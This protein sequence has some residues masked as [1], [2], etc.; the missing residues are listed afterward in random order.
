MC[1]I[2][3]KRPEVAAPSDETLKIMFE[4]NPDGGGVA[5]SYKG[6]LHI[7]KGL[8]TFDEFLDAAHK[9]PQDAP[10]IYHT[11]IQTSGG[12][13]K[14][15]THPF[16]ID[17]DIKKQRQTKT[18]TTN[19]SA[20]AHNGIF[21]QYK[22]KDLNND[23][24]QF[25]TNNIAPLKALKDK[26]GGK[27]TDADIKNIIDELTGSSRVAILT[28]DGTLETYG[29]GWTTDAG[30]KYSNSGYKKF[31]YK[32][33]FKNYELF[34]DYDKYCTSRARA[35]RQK[36]KKFDTLCDEYLEKWGIDEGEVWQYYGGSEWR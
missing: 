19:G 13:N 33:Y 14:E 36:S 27:I 20:L 8:M 23:T 29:S 35:L 9:I 10:A 30:I 1:I 31:E 5:W 26:T 18:I 11:R 22:R 17:A 2:A 32:N 16:L 28:A 24:T 6:A 21:N 15:L 25:I 3:V 34:D 12:V 7:I 4:K